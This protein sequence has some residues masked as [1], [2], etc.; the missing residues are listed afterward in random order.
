MR[1]LN[2]F[3]AASQPKADT[4]TT[5]GCVFNKINLKVKFAI[6]QFLNE[7]FT[8]FMQSVKKCYKKSM[9]LF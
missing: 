6:S 7:L 5:L 8:I 3:M 1:E 4:M 9:I 2:N